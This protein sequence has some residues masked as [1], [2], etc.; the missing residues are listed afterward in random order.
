MT[1]DSEFATGL[2]RCR[3]AML[4]IAQGIIRDRDDAEDAVQSAYLRAWHKRAQL[5]DPG[6]IKYWLATTV[7][8][9]CYALLRAKKKWTEAPEEFR[10]TACDPAE[11]VTAGEALNRLRRAFSRLPRTDQ[12]VWYL[13]VHRHF[14]HREIAT[15]VH[16]SEGAV[17]ARLH[18][19]RIALREALGEPATT[20]RRR[21][22]ASTR[23]PWSS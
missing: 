15:I 23:S 17:G 21:G 14:R 12:L 3:P 13:K 10:R 1:D 6:A 5:G 22:P 9:E 16:S 2:A 7:R 8:R 11:V 18:R 4:V 19:M 20:A